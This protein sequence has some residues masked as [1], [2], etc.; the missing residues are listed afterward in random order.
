MK[1]HLTTK[2][3]II[4]LT[5]ALILATVSCNT[6]DPS[7]SDLI[8]WY[9]QP[10]AEWEE[11]LPAGNGRLGAMVFGGMD[12]IQIQLN[13]ESIW[14]GRQQNNLN[15]KA[16]ENLSAIRQL[17]FEN[18]NKEALELAKRTL[19]SE[20]KHIRSY[21]PLGD[22]KIHFTDG[23]KSVSGYK[24]SLD[25][26][27]GIAR[28]E[29]QRNG[30]YFLQETF[31]SA[32]N[33]VIVV[34][35][36]SSDPNGISCALGLTRQQ[37]AI[38]QIPAVDELRLMGQ[39]VDQPDPLYDNG[40]EHMR[41]EG[42]LKVL[43]TDGQLSLDGNHLALKGASKLT[44]AITAGTDYN[45]EQLNFDRSID[46]ASK[47]ENIFNAVENQSYQTLKAVH[48]AD[49]AALMNRVDLHLVQLEKDTVPTDIRLKQVKNGKEDLHL[50]ELYFQYGRYLLMGSSR[51]PGV[52]PA[53]LQG[54]WNP[55]MK[56]PWSS[57]FH[58]NINLQMNYWPAEVCNLSE[59]LL[60]MANFFHNISNGP[61][62]DAAKMYGCE[63]WTIHHL[64]DP[65][66]RTGIMDGIEWGMFPLAGSWLCFPVWRHFE[67][68]NDT[69]YLKEIAW[70]MMKKN[71]RFVMDF[72]IEA[73]NGELVTSPSYSPENHFY[74][75]GSHEHMR[76]TYAPTMDIQIINELFKY[77]KQAAKIIGQEETFVQQ[78]S[79][80]Q[81]QLPPV[82]IG[83]NGTLQEWVKDYEE[84]E[85]GHRHVSHLLGLHPGTTITP[86]TPELFEAARKTI[87]R[88]LEHGGGGTGWSRAWTISFFA[89]FLDGDKANEHL[90]A[91]L[92]LSTYNNLFDAH[93]PFQIDGNFGGTAGIAEMLLQSHNQQIVVLPALPSSWKNGHIKGLKARGN[94]EIDLFWKDGHLQKITLISK[95]GQKC[96]LKYGDREFS[97]D[98]VAGE[99]YSL[100]GNLE[101]ISNK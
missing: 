19:I 101:L 99:S 85:P 67:Y 43:D 52:L 77:C 18:K 11:A 28:V 90:Q 65:F 97:F 3:S 81:K 49:H 88:R 100:N 72:L 66:G 95:D 56:A 33:D 64:T 37:D 60:P 8:L 34:H 23:S 58:V 46:P 82:R 7:T 53:N 75:P 12:T 41:F 42:R 21:Q 51:Q 68:T 2:G 76:L 13:E 30:H 48:V 1:K 93:P 4:V 14:A 83:K 73:P 5:G 59:T 10:A 92:A 25:L 15:P 70:P 24:R 31:V 45:V 26:V 79:E 69:T 84:A 55:H 29:C 32:P 98:T 9:T 71:A 36:E 63:G 22:L 91:L 62:M 61:G 44:L 80:V 74:L 87:E 47:V 96:K 86:D 89:R 16:K 38:V 39:I 20:N 40:G 6:K 78:L 57:D 27:S 35:L 94:F 50:V 17:L 54:I